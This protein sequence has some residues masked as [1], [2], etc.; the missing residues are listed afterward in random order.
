M[1]FGIN[2]L[3][4]FLHLSHR[5]SLLFYVIGSWLKHK[6]MLYVYFAQFQVSSLKSLLFVTRHIVTCHI[7]THYI[8]LIA[9]QSHGCKHYKTNE[10]QSSSVFVE[11]KI[12]KID[13]NYSVV[14]C[15]FILTKLILLKK[16]KITSNY[17][18][19]FENLIA[20]APNRIN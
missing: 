20:S 14:L 16:N 4:I 18:A 10:L 3:Q 6:N 5:H 12:L 13:K 19:V 8:F 11:K 9:E 2:L 1:I 15:S 17:F 7:V